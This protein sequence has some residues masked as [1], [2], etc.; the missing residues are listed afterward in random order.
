MRE[1]NYPSFPRDLDMV[2]FEAF[3]RVCHVGE[4]APNGEL[5]DAGDGTTV[6]LSRFWRSGPALIEF[7]S[8]T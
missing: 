3:P 2:D 4:R 6:R 8:I 1:Y 5:V 7:G